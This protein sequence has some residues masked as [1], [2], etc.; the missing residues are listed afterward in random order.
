MVE[1]HPGGNT[2]IATQ[3]EQRAPADSCSFLVVSLSF[4]LNPAMIANL[5][6]IPSET[7][8]RLA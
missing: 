8:R 2:L 6:T 7:A 1:K 4:A 3:S 5:P